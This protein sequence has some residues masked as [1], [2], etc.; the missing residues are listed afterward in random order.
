MLDRN[1]CKATA[2][3]QVSLNNDLTKWAENENRAIQDT[4]TIKV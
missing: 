1:L 3:A 2:A 4:G